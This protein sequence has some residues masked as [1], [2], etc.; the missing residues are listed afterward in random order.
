MGQK[1]SWR[2]F[3]RRKTT[4]GLPPED[5]SIWVDIAVRT[6]KTFLKVALG[7]FAA[8]FVP[9]KWKA[10]VTAAVSAGSCAAINYAAKRMQKLLKD[11]EQPETGEEDTDDYSEG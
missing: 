11:S 3:W 1:I 8:S 5:E 10:A 9:G 6:V 7:V 4:R 2:R